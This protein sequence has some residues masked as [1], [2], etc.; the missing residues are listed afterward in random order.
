MRS[1]E[2]WC[3]EYDWFDCGGKTGGVCAKIRDIQADAVDG[4]LKAI[5][6]FCALGPHLIAFGT[7][8]PKP[9]PVEHKKCPGVRGKR[10]SYH[11][12]PA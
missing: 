6:D 5:K 12:R 2:E 10:A 7:L 4:V 9:P 1:A 11:P 8:Q 3:K